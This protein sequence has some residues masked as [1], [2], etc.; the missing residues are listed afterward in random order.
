MSTEQCARQLARIVLDAAKR[1]EES[2]DEEQKVYTIGLETACNDVAREFGEPQ[3]G[4]FARL[5]LDGW[6]N[7][8]LDWAT[9]VLT[10]APSTK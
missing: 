8:V 10:A 9:E 5:A 1:H 3:L 2:W 7:D 4:E 6:Q